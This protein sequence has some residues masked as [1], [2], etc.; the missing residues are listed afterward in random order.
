MARLGDKCQ[1]TATFT[2][3]LDSTFLPM[4]LLYREKLNVPILNLIFL[5]NLTSSTPPIIGPMKTPVFVILKKYSF[6]M[7]KKFEKTWMEERH[8]RFN[9]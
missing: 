9:F 6:R 2:V 8:R 1:V 3:F 7:Q 4:P 5:M